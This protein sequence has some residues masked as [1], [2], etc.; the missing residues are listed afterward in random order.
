M[1]MTSLGGTPPWD[2]CI[3]HTPP[4]LTVCTTSLGGTPPW[5]VCISHTPPKADCVYDI[6]GMCRSVPQY[7]SV[8]PDAC[9]KANCIF[10]E[11]TI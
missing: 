11:F 1:C 9:Q 3:S 4:R 5:D 10:H 2:V 7:N 8:E 6:L